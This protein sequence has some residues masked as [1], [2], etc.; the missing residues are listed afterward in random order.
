MAL[1][2][3]F[4]NSLKDF[5]LGC[6]N[7]SPFSVF[8][9]TVTGVDGELNS[10]TP[11]NLGTGSTS[12]LTKRGTRMRGAARQSSDCKTEAMLKKGGKKQGQLQSDRSGAY[13]K[14]KVSVHHS[15]AV[16]PECTP[17]LASDTFLPP[18]QVN[19]CF[20]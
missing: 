20:L 5:Y 14:E 9:Q 1:F 18:S 10:Q 12:I 4:P 6:H 16:A 13:T 19:H 7:A 2:E 8:P 17:S 11:F 3:Q 15:A